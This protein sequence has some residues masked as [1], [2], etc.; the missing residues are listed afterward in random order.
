MDLGSGFNGGLSGSISPTLTITQQ[1]KALGGLGFT[2]RLDLADGFAQARRAGWRLEQ[3]QAPVTVSAGVRY[4]P[5]IGMDYLSASVGEIQPQGPAAPR[6]R[7]VVA[8]LVIHAPRWNAKVSAQRLPGGSE[9]PLA[10]QP[11]G[12]ARLVG[13]SY[14]S[15]V[16]AVSG[17]WKVPDGAVVTATA[18][19]VDGGKDMQVEMGVRMRF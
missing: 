19:D 1:A 15:Q 5:L 16:V 6:A 14:A 3:V 8:S 17:A 4:I 13:D 9:I 2:G 11:V 7:G 12:P 18:A 10:Y